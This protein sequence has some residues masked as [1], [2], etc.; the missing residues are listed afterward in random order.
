M[1]EFVCGRS[2]LVGNPVLIVL[3]QGIGYCLV[4]G[5]GKDQ[6]ADNKSS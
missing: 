1:A 6:Q 5:Q 4:N 2:L 3:F